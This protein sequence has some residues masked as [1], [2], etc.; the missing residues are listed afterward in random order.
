MGECEE[1]DVSRSTASVRGTIFSD[2]F[3]VS[4]LFFNSLAHRANTKLL[5]ENNETVNEMLR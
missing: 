3:E 4:T 5:N 2:H 1:R